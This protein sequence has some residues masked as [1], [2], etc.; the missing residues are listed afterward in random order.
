MA[1]SASGSMRSMSSGCKRIAVC[2]VRNLAATTRAYFSSLKASSLK[3]T[4]KV[5]TG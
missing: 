1:A 4:E 5:W 2:S 3:T